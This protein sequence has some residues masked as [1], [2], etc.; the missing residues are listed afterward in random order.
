M[1]HVSPARATPFLPLELTDRVIDYLHKDTATLRICSQVHRTWTKATRVHLFY[2]I[3]I[4]SSEAWGRLKDVLITSPSIGTCVTHVAINGQGTYLPRVLRKE[5]DLQPEFTLS[6]HLHNTKSLELIA[7]ALGD[8]TDAVSKYIRTNF[9]QV[10]QVRL[11]AV[12]APTPTVL[13]E[14]VLTPR[15]K[16]VSVSLSNATV[17]DPI[18]GRAMELLR[19]RWLEIDRF[20]FSMPMDL[21]HNWMFHHDEHHR[22]PKSNVE[23]LR[24]HG[25]HFKNVDFVVHAVKL[26]GKSL[27]SLDLDISNTLTYNYP[28]TIYF[29]GLSTIDTLNN[30]T[31][32][33]SH[34]LLAC[35]ANLQRLVWRDHGSS[36]ARIPTEICSILGASACLEHLENIHLRLSRASLG[37]EEMTRARMQDAW[38]PLRELLDSRP[39]PHLKSLNIALSKSWCVLLFSQDG[40]YSLFFEGVFPQLHASGKLHVRVLNLHH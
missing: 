33:E 34:E 12:S 36:A 1:E 13:Q 2:S 40:D 31:T 3:V 20:A 5:A 30:I 11:N 9:L 18:G 21:H 26:L 23:H 37:I 17:S 39:L 16:L 10:K 35:T 8:S 14:C 19:Y 4:S 38:K 32:E 25:I 24:I 29:F 7:I 15:T 28:G 22:Y 27:Q 6:Y